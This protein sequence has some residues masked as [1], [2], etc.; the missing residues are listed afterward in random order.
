VPGGF[1]VDERELGVADWAF[2]H[3]REAGAGTDTLPAAQARW[4]PLAASG[5]AVGIVGVA[6]PRRG[7]DEPAQRRLVEAYASQ[8]A[9]ALE[10]VQLAEQTRHAQVEIEAERLRTALL[11]SLS[12]DLRSP[13]GVITGA[14]TA[15]QR[16]ASPGAQAELIGS[17]LAEC[18]RMARLIDNLLDMIRLES[19]ALEV[20]RDWQ[21]LEEPVGAA[22][23]R[24]GDRL[25]DHPTEVRLPPDLPLVPLDPVLIEQVMMNL[26]ENAIRYTPPGSP[27]EITARAEA[28]ELVVSVADRGPGIEPGEDVRIFDKFYRGRGERVPGG[29][30]L[31]L[32]ICRGIVTAHGGR[33]WAENRPGGGAVFSFTLPV[34][35][36]PPV[37]AEM[38]AAQAPA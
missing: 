17:I 14:A 20:Q 8:T 25:A 9:L 30:G 29:V 35:G 38:D 15:L 19:G 6:N 36:T 27:I 23:L 10:R 33:I 21:T 32:A 26:L 4:V 28:S 24:L 3:G 12:H 2:R 31:G 1:V 5:V 13:L 16:G 18:G 37:A 7:L 34:T 22:L 11:S